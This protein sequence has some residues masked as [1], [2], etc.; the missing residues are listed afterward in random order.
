[1]DA[2]KRCV[3]LNMC[4]Y[5]VY[6]HVFPN[7]KRYIGITKTDVDKRWMNGKGYK[8]QPKIAKAIEKYGWENVTH[9]ILAVGLTQEMAN[10]LEQFYIE[11]YD[12][13][14]NGY[15]A[16]IGGDNILTCYLDSHVLEMLNY[17]QKHFNTKDTIMELVDKDRCNYNGA[18]FW[19]EAAS[20]IEAKHGK[21]SATSMRDVDKFWWYM[22][23][24]Y[25]L[26]EKIGNGEDVNEWREELYEDMMCRM[27]AC[28]TS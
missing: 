13:M 16:T 5:I 7:G 22:L 24:Y 15:N 21:M 28:K 2:G 9:E 4:D 27:Y 10:T 12:S 25:I 17:A 23:Q 3:N 20:A 8:T 11:K 19:N 6:S 1:M 14:N 26:N 18:Q